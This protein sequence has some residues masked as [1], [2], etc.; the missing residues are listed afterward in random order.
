[1][2][3]KLIAKNLKNLLIE[4]SRESQQPANTNISPFMVNS[5]I[6]NAILQRR[7]FLACRFGWWETYAVGLRDSKGEISESIRAKMWNTPGIFPP[8][9]DFFETFYIEYTAAMAEADIVGLMRCP[10]EKH[11]ID[12]FS[13]NSYLCEL[14]D[15]EPYYQPNPWSR[16]LTGLRVLIVH[17]FAKSIGLQFQSH[18]C[19][20]FQN[21]EIL[22]EFTLLAQKSPQTLCGNTDGFDN[23]LEALNNLKHK[24]SSIKFDVAIVGCGAYGL[25]V[26][27]YI[28]KLGKPCI[29]LGGATQTLFGII[30]SRWTK[31]NPVKFLINE[32]WIRPDE[33][34]KPKNW[35]E[36]EDGCYW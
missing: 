2:N 33:S 30:G 15:L 21:Q 36:A 4:L 5:A 26:A 35:Q 7:P 10:Y 12:R 28:K 14:Q 34:E 22:P 13:A 17:P 27:A 9:E 3:F 8:T 1:M 19:S 11:V 31:H 29:H 23:W 6:A 20:I 25:P 24:I 32:F 16:S 18:R